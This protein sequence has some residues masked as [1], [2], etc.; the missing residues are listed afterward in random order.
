MLEPCLF[1]AAGAV[2]LEGFWVSALVEGFWLSVLLGGFWFSVLLGCTLGTGWSSSFLAVVAIELPFDFTA[3]FK[4]AV[5][6]G[7][8]LDRLLTFALRILPYCWPVC[9]GSSVRSVAKIFRVHSVK[10]WKLL[11]PS[12]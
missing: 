5:G 11:K 10:D 1:K 7:V 4:V 9:I 3:D 12:S 8:F 6:S 2:F